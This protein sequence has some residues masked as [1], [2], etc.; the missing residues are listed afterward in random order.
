IQNSR[1]IRR[2]IIAAAIANLAGPLICGLAG[3]IVASTSNPM[4]KSE[5]ATIE[6]FKE[7]GEH[8]AISARSSSICWRIGELEQLTNT[9]CQFTLI[10][11]L[12]HLVVDDGFVDRLGCLSVGSPV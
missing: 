2:P 6:P 7:T 4:V 5:R 8:A 9:P 10:A 12:H 3:L 1:L 11:S